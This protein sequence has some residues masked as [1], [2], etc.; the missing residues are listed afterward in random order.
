MATCIL[1]DTEETSERTKTDKELPFI[2]SAE[3]VGVGGRRNGKNRLK[4]TK[5]ASGGGKATGRGDEEKKH[6]KFH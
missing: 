4:D 1:L 2:S 5:G 3:G 6:T